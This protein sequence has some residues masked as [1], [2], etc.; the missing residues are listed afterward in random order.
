ML[1]SRAL[2]GMGPCFC[3]GE[4]EAEACSCPGLEGALCPGAGLCSC[5]CPEAEEA[6]CSGAGLWLL[7]LSGLLLGGGAVGL[8]VLGGGLRAAGGERVAR[9]GR[10]AR[11]AHGLLI[12]FNQGG[13]QLYELLLAG[14][15][16]LKEVYRVKGGEQPVYYQGDKIK[17]EKGYIARAALPAAL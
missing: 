3:S 13:L 11:S 16:Q 9:G 2:P 14:N 7:L 5:S 17:A 1:G 6:F 4:K 10:V 12:F 8:L 15:L